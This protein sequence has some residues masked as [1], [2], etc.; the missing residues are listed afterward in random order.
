VSTNNHGVPAVVLTA[1]DSALIK[2]S[3]F[4]RWILRCAISV[5]FLALPA[6][7]TVALKFHPALNSIISLSFVIA[8]CAAAWWGGAWAGIL[9]SCATIPVLTLA[10][11]NGKVFL[12]PNFDPLGLLLFV[13]I[14]V[15]V[16]SVSKYRKR[17]EQV[18]RSANAQLETR[19]RERTA[20]L[21]HANAA[22]QHQFAELESLYAELP[23]GLCFLDKNLRY[24]RI[25]ERL[26][27]MNGFA[28][29]AHLGRGLRETISQQFADTV[30]PLYRR[31]LLTGEPF[32]DF[33]VGEASTN[34]ERQQR[35]WMVGCS[36]VKA[37]VEDVLGLQVIVQDIT[38]RK[39]SEEALRQANAEIKNREEQFR[40]LAN[41]IPQLSWMANGD[42]S[43]LWC[44]DRWITYTGA[45]LAQM[46]DTGW[47]AVHDPG[48]LPAFKQTWN[49]SLASGEPFEME[50]PLRA[51]D[52]CFRWFLTRIIPVR[53]GVRQVSR[54]F[55]TATDIDELKRSREA[56]IE[57][58]ARFRSMADSAPVMIWVSAIDKTFTW[59]NKP[60]LGFTGNSLD[61]E[62]AH[63]WSH[64][65]HSSDLERCVETY[66]SCFDSRKDF[67]MEYRR[68][69]HDG[70]WRWV[71]SHGTPRLGGK[72]EFL[73]YIG[74]CV[75]IHDRREMEQHLRRAN[76]DLQQFAYSASHDLQEPIRTVVIYSQLVGKRYGAKLDETAQT[77]LD[78][79]I[80]AAKRMEKLVH[81]LLLY[82]QTASGEEVVPET[83][84]AGEALSGALANLSLAV[85]EAG[86]QVTND[87]LPVVEIRSVHLQQLFQ[88]LIGNAIK[89]R[90]TQQPRIHIS[91]R[92]QHDHWLFSVQDNGIGIDADYKER[93]FGIFKRLHTAD[94]YSGTGI[95]L[96]ICKRIIERYRGRIW[97]ESELGKGST[98][99]FTIQS[100]TH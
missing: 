42:G 53:D 91:A 32:L 17:I 44:N 71:L 88:N 26:A 55:G 94:K 52:G 18:L 64:G 89:Y 23:V 12:P 84:D 79:V 78:Y 82:T 65:I 67:V 77:F 2:S 30:E 5:S 51:S 41:A 76:T 24:V 35:T 63:G 40:T 47:E 10:A 19:V 38:D 66:R 75:D 6:A 86:A 34:G 56:L 22:I 14:S 80:A 83:A 3:G 62:L 81:D 92:E 16:S 69:R 36:P 99:F 68:R 59:F 1:D 98:F 13:L 73:G 85:N 21:E 87:P 100:R 20:D 9:A 48:I 93:I 49:R 11:T 61:R 57:S 70:E 37:E 31:V 25:N 58:E 72:G 29:S 60:W 8:V 90:G 50:F 15:L 54:W 39:R 74:S 33:E 96:A 27:N 95:G 28:V 4:A 46:Q 97:V 43:F 7:V 45:T